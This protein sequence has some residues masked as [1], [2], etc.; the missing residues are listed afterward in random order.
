MS[1]WT[2]S[3]SH[4]TAASGV[5]DLGP[6]VS[7]AT[8]PAVP[9]PMQTTSQTKIQRRVACRLGVESVMGPSL[10]RGAGGIGGR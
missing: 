2:Y 4:E 3:R 9:H 5:A 1:I 6:V 10:A 8:L 7:A